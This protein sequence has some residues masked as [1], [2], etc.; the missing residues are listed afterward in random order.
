M[1]RSDWGVS[2][3]WSVYDELTFEDPLELGV[4][5]VTPIVPVLSALRITAPTDWMNTATANCVLSTSQP[6]R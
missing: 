3:E 1:P 2:D 5:G 4:D 6:K